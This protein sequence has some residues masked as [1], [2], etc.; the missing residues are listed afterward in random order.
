MRQS[1]TSVKSDP[2]GEGKGERHGRVHESSAVLP[3]YPDE[4]RRRQPV[5]ED[6]SQHGPCVGVG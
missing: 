4:R 6:R 3:E 5:A 1:R 2:D